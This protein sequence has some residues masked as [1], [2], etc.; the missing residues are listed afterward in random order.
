MERAGW[1]GCRTQSK[2][3]LGVGRSPMTRRPHPRYE[4]LALE[5]PVDSFTQAHPPVTP[6]SIHPDEQSRMGRA[7]ARQCLELSPQ[8]QL[9]PQYNFQYDL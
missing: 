3:G 6:A 4:L 5:L 2:E 1:G 9:Q 8:P 7:R